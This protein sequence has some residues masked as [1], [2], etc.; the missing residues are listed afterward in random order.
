MLFVFGYRASKIRS[1]KISVLIHNS[2]KYSNLNSCTVSIHFQKIIDKVRQFFL[3]IEIH[4]VMLLIKLINLF[5]FKKFLKDLGKD[6][7]VVPDS[8][9]VISRTAFKDSS[10]YY[11]LDKK[12]V[13]FKEIAKILRSHGVDLDHNRFLILQVKLY[14]YFLYAHYIPLIMYL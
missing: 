11:E 2:N 6:Y 12:K 1:K 5:L 7:E 3:S 13:Q 4:I 9:F 10:S 8:E 14:I